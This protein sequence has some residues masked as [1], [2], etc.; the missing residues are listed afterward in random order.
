M[1]SCLGGSLRWFVPIAVV[2]AA[3]A[4]TLAAAPASADKEGE[5]DKKKV[6]I[7]FD[8]VSKYDKGKLGQKVGEMIWKKIE[9]QKTFIVPDTV[10]DIRDICSQNNIKIG[11]D[12]PQEKVREGGAQGVR[13]P[14]RHLG[15]RRV[16]A[17]QRGG[18]STTWF[19]TASISPRRSP[20]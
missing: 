20:R 2:M 5:G 16:G 3:L 15:E 10:Q 7:P 14:D 8:L 13:R 6:V 4:L 9:R 1:K 19:S 12:T 11:P 18:R 17:R